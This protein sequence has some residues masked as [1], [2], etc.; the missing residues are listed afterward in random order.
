MPPISLTQTQ[1]D[2][3]VSAINARPKSS[4]IYD[5]TVTGSAVTSIVIPA[6]DIV[7]HK[8]YRIELEI[9]NSTATAFSL[10]LYSNTNLTASNYSTEVINTAG[11]TNTASTVANSTIGY[12]D[13]SSNSFIVM[14][15]SLLSGGFI[16]WLSQCSR[17]SKVLSSLASLSGLNKIAVTNLTALTLTSSVANSI[18]IG[19]RIRIY[20]GDC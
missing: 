18:G 1:L 7:L 12:C 4:L 15:L 6:L 8:S 3:L 9:L 5:S 17:G 10:F 16:R 20:R 11:T 13:I 2:S 14:T 19:S